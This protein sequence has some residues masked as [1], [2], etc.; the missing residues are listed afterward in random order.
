MNYFVAAPAC[1][2]SAAVVLQCTSGGSFQRSP[3]LCVK[4]MMAV[5]LW[6]A[7][8]FLKYY[9]FNNEFNRLP[10]RA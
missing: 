10:L 6:L 7:R 5:D 9:G 4:L 3:L 8:Q 2:K 1:V